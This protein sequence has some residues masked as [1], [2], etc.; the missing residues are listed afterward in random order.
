MKFSGAVQMLLIDAKARRLSPRTAEF[1]ELQLMRVAKILGDKDVRKVTT[2]DLRLALGEC[3]T[4]SSPHRYR[5]LTRLF[6]FLVDEEVLS[7][8]PAARL[9]PPKVEHKVRRGLTP[10]ELQKCYK[11]VKSLGG[12]RGIRDT[13]LFTLLVACGLRASELTGLQDGDV[14]LGGA[15]LLIHGKGNKQR[16]VPI[17]SKL[18]PILARYKYVRTH[19]VNWDEKGTTFFRSRKGTPLTTPALA[20]TIVR[21]GQKAGIKLHT[22]LLRHTWATLYMSHDGADVLS[23]K[24]LGGWSQISMAAHYAKPSMSKLQRSANAF[25]P[26]NDLS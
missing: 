16:V 22:H 24:A 8:S 14:D 19:S 21:I 20:Q 3:P 9:R 17:P 1:Y 26:I 6:S 25:S 23:L 18:L 11:A 5:S 7:V 15:E 2:T 12:F 10:D 13:A 4:N